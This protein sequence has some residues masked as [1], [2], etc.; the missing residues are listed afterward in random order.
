MRYT[1]SVKIDSLYKPILRRFRAYFRAKFDSHYNVK[2]FQHW[3]VST[4]IKN[5]RTFLIEDL[6]VPEAL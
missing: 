3:T 4:Y 2:H 1:P 6:N 5:V